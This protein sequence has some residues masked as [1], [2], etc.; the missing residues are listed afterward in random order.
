M[1]RVD[2]FELERLVGKGG[3]GEVWR[4]LDPE[5]GATVALKLTREDADLGRFAREAE[6]LA[7]LE[8]PGIVRHVAHGVS[9]GQGYLAMEWLEGEDLSVRLRGGRLTVSDGLG[10]VRRVAD[11]L[12]AAHA[13]GIVH[14]DLKPSNLFLVGG[15]LASVRVLDFGIARV[16]G[17]T[18]T[19]TGA[20]IGTPGYMSPEQ[21]AGDGGIDA[22]TDVFALGCVLFECIAGRAP[23]VGDH[24][25]A[26]LAKLL[27]DAAPTVAS[28]VPEVPPAV[29]ALVGTMLAKRREARPADGAAVCALIDRVLAGGS[30]T[31]NAAEAIGTNERRVT[32]VVL[33]RS[34]TSGSAAGSAPAGEASQA[35]QTSA[36]SGSEGRSGLRVEHLADGTSF[37]LL[38]RL[39]TPRD[40]VLA[41]CRHATRLLLDDAT[42]RV[43]IATDYALDAV[44]VAVGPAIDRA[45]AVLA[46][47][48]AGVI[49]LDAASAALVEGRYEI[50]ATSFGGRLRGAL[51][52][53][54]TAGGTRTTQGEAPVVGRERELRLLETAL[55][56][57]ESGRAGLVLLLGD[58]GLGKSALARA[59]RK[60]VAARDGGAALVEATADALDASVPFALLRALLAHGAKLVDG[61]APSDAP[62]LDA[63]RKHAVPSMD[64]LAFDLGAWLRALATDRLAVVVLDDMHWADEPS[65]RALSRAMLECEEAP[66]LVVV[67]GRP[68]TAERFGALLSPL[69]PVEVRLRPLSAKGAAELAL[70]LGGDALSESARAEVVERAQGSP[71]VIEELV[72]AAKRGSIGALPASVLGVVQ[73]NVDRLAPASRRVLRAASVLG[74]RFALDAVLAVLG[75]G[76]DRTQAVTAF[77]EA[78]R[79][80]L[81]R[82]DGDG[83]FAFRHALTHDAVYAMLPEA[84]RAAAHG[85]AAQWLEQRERVDAAVLAH[86]LARA[87]DSERAIPAFLDA[88]RE[89]AAA[90]D[91]GAVVRLEA[92][93]AALDAAAPARVELLLLLSRAMLGGPAAERAAAARAGLARADDTSPF[94]PRLLQELVTAE[95]TEDALAYALANL[96]RIAPTS[97][98]FRCLAA[99]QQTARTCALRG[100]DRAARAC[101]QRHLEA[102]I[103]PH[104]SPIWSVV[105]R[106]YEHA[107]TGILG[108]IAGFRGALTL[109]QANVLEWC[110]WLLLQLG[111]LEE[112]GQQ[113]DAFAPLVRSPRSLMAALLHQRR[114]D[115]ATQTRALEDA[116]AHYETASRVAEALNDAADRE[117]LR[118]RLAAANV[119]V[120]LGRYDQ[121]LAHAPSL[122][123]GLATYRGLRPLAD[124]AIATALLHLGRR[125]EAEPVARRGL[126][127]LCEG[128]VFDG[129]ALRPR[130]QLARVLLGCGARDEAIAQAK[131]ALDDIALYL[132]NIS[133][134]E[135][136]RLFLAN[137]P[138]VAPALEL[139]KE[140]GLEVP[141]A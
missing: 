124:A 51:D 101:H 104:G 106:S 24:A 55:E 36:P 83:A 72:R 112:A 74:L 48:E 31:S 125:D 54:T 133:T 11:A 25:M 118:A 15:E 19:G 41:A 130:A 47:V 49:G 84:E 89:A 23:F 105:S 75:D 3:M 135:R 81:V 14:R 121:V 61:A 93:V 67:Q 139:G 73:A 44:A 132:P 9:E 4:A 114:G 29:D 111:R 123:P 87:G 2:R 28:L 127:Y 6:L 71:Y 66:V 46:E 85:R 122:E 35:T 43:A 69:G 129:G 53:T 68:A 13:R 40:H 86:H 119:L 134:V 102:G 12:A 60:Q 92:E 64:E 109:D 52:A 32:T 33:W 38:S 10:L 34:E 37:A 97:A 50:D 98:T 20:V 78:K 131:E 141:E 115:L 120:M 96:G 91:R 45:S 117:T 16:E 7:S 65:V 94:R 30:I 57:A 90:G 42:T 110:A 116:L 63:I 100:D 99:V 70:R 27:I 22:R 62:A 138:G 82:A 76:A 103:D 88:A 136:R 59:L 80:E 1:R 77:D 5:S 79:A 107:V 128:W 21:A 17:T 108:Q 137:A 58:A 18:R 8:H 113:I 26:V 95:P 140:L 39:G 126:S 56:D